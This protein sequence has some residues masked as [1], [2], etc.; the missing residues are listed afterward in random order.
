MISGRDRGEYA[1]EMLAYQ[2]DIDAEDVT[3][4]RLAPDMDLR[5]LIDDDR[6]LLKQIIER[7][8]TPRRT[9]VYVHGRGARAKVIQALTQAFPNK[10]ELWRI[11]KECKEIVVE[12]KD[13]RRRVLAALAPLGRVSI[14]KE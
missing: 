12:G 5:P 2:L 13:A 3:K 8:Q 1:S 7:Q 10:Q 14:E 4:M 6:E 9:D 11:G